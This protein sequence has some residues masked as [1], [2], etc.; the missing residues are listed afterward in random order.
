MANSP[1]ELLEE[2]SKIA[3]EVIRENSRDVE[4]ILA[5]LEISFEEYQELT[6]QEVCEDLWVK[7]TFAFPPFQN[8][9]QEE[10]K[11]EAK[12]ITL[13]KVTRDKRVFVL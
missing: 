5:N 9:G 6:A 2:I 4:R 13:Q 3:R 8:F 10:L 1:E 12:Q 11:K 7:A